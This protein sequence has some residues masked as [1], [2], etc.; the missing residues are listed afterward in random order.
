ARV[1]L[2]AF[3]A[4]TRA[5]QQTA[6]DAGADLV[7]VPLKLEWMQDSQADVQQTRH[8]V[9]DMVRELRADIVHANQFAAACADVNVP[10]ILTLHSDVLSW[11]H[12]TYGATDVPAEWHCYAALVREALLRADAVVAV[13]DFL[14]R[15]IAQLYATDR[16]FEVIHNGWP[17]HPE[18]RA[19]G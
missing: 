12:W 18:P 2:L 11:R 17:P 1:T 5:Q 10:V 6:A 9:R 14:S 16:R 13:S 7:S 4:P 8:V 19:R 3:G 15:E